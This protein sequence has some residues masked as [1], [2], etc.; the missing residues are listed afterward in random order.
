[1]S[2]QETG[3]VQHMSGFS[4]YIFLSLYGPGRPTTR[5]VNPTFQCTILGDPFA[6]Y[7]RVTFLGCRIGIKHRLRGISEFKM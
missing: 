5:L 2:R 4:V 7:K 1:M 6:Y 3:L